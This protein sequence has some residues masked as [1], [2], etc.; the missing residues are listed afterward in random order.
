MGTEIQYLNNNS[1]LVIRG[2]S[3]E[4]PNGIDVEKNEQ[5]FKGETEYERGT[6][7]Q[8]KA[9]GVTAAVLA[10]STNLDMNG[11]KGLDQTFSLDDS[12]QFEILRTVHDI[13]ASKNSI[14]SDT[15]QIQPIKIIKNPK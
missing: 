7:A 14:I 10:A 3:S 9:T 8:S 12:K 13:S 2:E 5:S 6:N 15:V 1:I 4:K 11:E